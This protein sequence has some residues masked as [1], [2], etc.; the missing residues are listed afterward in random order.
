MIGV[1]GV[2]DMG[3]P[4]TGHILDHGYEVVAYDVD[5]QRLSAT[6]AKGAKPASDVSELGRIADI[7]VLC[8][9][10]DEQMEAVTVELAAHGEPGRLIVVAGTHGLDAMRRAAAVTEPAGLRIIDAPVVY[11][12]LGAKEG[13]LLSLCGGETADVERA[14]PVMLCYSRGVEHVGPLGA[15]QLAKTCNNLLHWIHSVANFEALALAKRYGLD[16]QRM[17]EVLMKCPGDNGTL[18]RWDSTRFTWQEKDMDFVTALAQSGGLVLPL[19]GQV[20]QLVKTM[21]AD[22]VAALLYESECTYLGRRI[23]PLSA[24]DGGL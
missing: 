14:T 21:T 13:N 20:D 11:G 7:I 22:D 1:I 12:A 18:R 19:T 9:R 23:T 4:M 17:R 10:T 5:P 16:A 8:L 2:G 3:L 24:S 6:T 15:G